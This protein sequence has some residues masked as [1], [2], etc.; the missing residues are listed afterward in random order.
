MEK[1]TWT[2]PVAAV[3]QFMPNE[4]IAACFGISCI[5]GAADG[6][7]NTADPH[8][9]QTWGSYGTWHTAKSDGSGCGHVYNQFI[10][11][12]NNGTYTMIEKNARIAGGSAES[13]D[14]TLYTDNWGSRVNS[15]SSLTQ[16]QTVYWSTQAGYFTMY[17]YGTVNLLDETRP[18]RS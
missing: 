16:G 1:M 14:C 4:Y 3:E 7:A 2:R 6:G 18:L 5:A 17:H 11:E 8:N 15:W 10:V 9:H 13:L 12:E